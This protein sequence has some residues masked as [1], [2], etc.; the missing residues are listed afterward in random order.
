MT[1]YLPNS[2]PSSA[3]LL[4]H[5]DTGPKPSLQGSLRAAQ[6]VCCSEVREEA[7]G[8]SCH[9]PSTGYMLVQAAR[10]SEVPVLGHSPWPQREGAAVS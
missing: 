1:R 5:P 3:G 10:A 6:R 7:S 9:G 4:G 8:S 2:C